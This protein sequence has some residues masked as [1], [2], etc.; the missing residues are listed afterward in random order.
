MTTPLGKRKKAEFLTN[1]LPDNERELE[2]EQESERKTNRQWG[3]CDGT[4]CIT[5]D[6]GVILLHFEKRDLFFHGLRR[7][8]VSR[9]LK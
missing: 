6:D 7:L 5:G 2:R 4:N 1:L 8:Y 9:N 3:T